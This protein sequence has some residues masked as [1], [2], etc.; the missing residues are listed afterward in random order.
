MARKVAIVTGAGRG[1]GRA[2]AL[3]LAER[4]YAVVVNDLD[5]SLAGQRTGE[6]SAEEVVAEIV[7]KGGEAISSPLDVGDWESAGQLIAT[8]VDR[9]GQLDVLIN[10]AGIIRDMVLY[11]LDA[12]SFDAVIRVHLRGTVAA[13]HFAAVH[14]RE[15]HQANGPVDGRLINTTSASAFWG[16]P[17]QSNYTAAKGGIIAFTLTASRELERYGVTANV[18]APGA[19][20]RMLSSILNESQMAALDPAYVARLAAWLCSAEAADVT[21]R[22]FA[23]SGEHVDV[24]QGWDSG[25]SADIPASVTVDELSSILPGMI[26]KARVNTP[27][28]GG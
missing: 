26:A 18:I 21:G 12:D 3:A 23:V 20:S 10:N 5:V 24:I 25:S 22:I 16:N 2:H 7:G 6:S 19:S 27:L 9:Y 11:K 17:G 14:W 15:R 28:L 13:A 4:G 1:I 8:A